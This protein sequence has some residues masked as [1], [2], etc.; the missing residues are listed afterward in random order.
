MAVAGPTVSPRT[1]R[2]TPSPTAACSGATGAGCSTRAASSPRRWQ[3]RNWLVCV[4]EFK[5]R[6]RTQ[7]RPDR[8][9]ELYFLDEATAFAA[10]HRPCGECRY[11]DYQRFKAAWARADPSAGSRPGIS[12]AACTPTALARPARSPTS[13]RSLRCLTARSSSMTTPSG[14]SSVTPC[15]AGPSPATPP[16][17]AATTFPP[18]SPSAPR[19]PL[20]PPSAPATSRSSILPP[21]DPDRLRAPANP[22]D[23]SGRPWDAC[24]ETR[25]H[26]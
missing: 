1:A 22:W 2:C 5:G 26:A 21:T 14:S 11:R 8:L 4:L 6:R 19:A 9:T 13:L 10:G 17:A 23:A 15:A 20:S 7:W 25:R 18:R 24:A 12:T 16:R 3:G